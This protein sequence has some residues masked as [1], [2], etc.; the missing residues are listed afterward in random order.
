MLFSF[1]KGSGAGL[2]A[3]PV[4]A[5]G[6]RLDAVDRAP[7]EDVELRPVR[8]SEGEVLRLLGQRD[9]AERRA[10]GRDGLDARAG[11]HVDPPGDIDGDAVGAARGSLGRVSETGQP[12]EVASGRKRAVRRYG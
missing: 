4:D 10:L 12:G 9:H 6:Q 2:L 5:G 3:G 11:R 1:S 8:P 7:A